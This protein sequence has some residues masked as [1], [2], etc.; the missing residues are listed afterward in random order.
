MRYYVIQ[1]RTGGEDKYL[2]LARRAIQTA[3]ID[4]NDIGT[5]LWPRRRLRIRKKG[6][7]RDSLA[8]IFP[9]YIF[10]E[11][12]DLETSAYWLLKRVSGFYKFL[13]DNHHIEPLGGEDR[14]LLM[15]FLAFGEVVEKSRAYFD[16]NKRIKI[17][18]GALRGMEGRIVKVDRRKKRAKVLLNL[19]QNSFFIDFGFE[20]LESVKENEE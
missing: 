4:A 20:L 14:E 3:G 6:I 16:E 18:D 15:H 11:T 13:K 17:V 10:L 5:L 2:K 12:D 1:V 7:E 19:Y 9:G 8:S